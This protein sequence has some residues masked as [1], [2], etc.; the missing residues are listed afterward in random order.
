MLSGLIAELQSQL[1]DDQYTSKRIQ[2][3]YDERGEKR[4]HSRD[5]AVKYAADWLL[6]RT[7]DTVYV[8]DLTNVL[9][10]H[11]SSKVNQKTHAFWSHRKLVDRLE[12]TLG[13]VGITVEQMSEADSSSE[14]PECGSSEVSRDGDAYRCHACGLHAYID[15]AGAWNLLQS[16]VGPMAR[17]AA[18][19]AERDRDAPVNGTY[20][21]WDGHDWSPADWEQSRPVDQTSVS[22]PASSQ[23]G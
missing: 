12:L 5:A 17:P 18:L 1:P 23:P 3:V 9:D 15:V 20:W 14:C 19:S 13:D 21:E 16:E 11:W 8:G 10:T 7:V 2:R 22:K 6:A 4:D